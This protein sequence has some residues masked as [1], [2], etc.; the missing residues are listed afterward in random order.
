MSGMWLISYVVLWLLVLCGAVVVL[1]L[2]RELEELRARLEA[3]ERRHKLADREG[4]ATPAGSAP[5]PLSD[6]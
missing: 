6:P 1:L 2:A 3:V 5:R 4:A